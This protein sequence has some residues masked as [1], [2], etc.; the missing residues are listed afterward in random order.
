MVIKLLFFSRY[1]QFVWWSSSACCSVSDVCYT[2]MERLLS[3][4]TLLTFAHWRHPSPSFTTLRGE[5]CVGAS[6]VQGSYSKNV[7]SWSWWIAI[8]RARFARHTLCCRAAS[9]G[10]IVW[11]WAVWLR[12]L[13]LMQYTGHLGT[14]LAAAKHFFAD[15]LLNFVKTVKQPHNVA[16]PHQIINLNGHF[17]FFVVIRLLITSY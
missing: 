1:C 3:I 8:T 10:R 5:D 16:L 14:T 12:A 15:A 6:G 13:W 7:R 11:W 17:S 4:A 2:R 9:R